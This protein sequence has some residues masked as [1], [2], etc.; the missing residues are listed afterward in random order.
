MF[1][2]IQNGL[3]FTPMPGFS[4]ECSDTQIWNVVNFIRS[5]QQDQAPLLNLPAPTA[6]QR[7]N[8][9]VRH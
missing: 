3:G 8:G 7:R 4:K 6:D 9:A 1:Y 5:M 2:I